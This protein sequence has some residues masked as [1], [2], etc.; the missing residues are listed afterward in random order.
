MSALDA[1][2]EPGTCKGAGWPYA[3]AGK[4]LRV[5]RQSAPTV[6]S[7]LTLSTEPVQLLS[8]LVVCV[9]APVSPAPR[10]EL[11][12]LAGWS[13]DRR[14]PRPGPAGCPVPASTAGSE[15]ARV[16]RRRTLL[17][18]GCQPPHAMSSSDVEDVGLPF[19]CPVCDREIDSPTPDEPSEAPV[20]PTPA[21]S[22]TAKGKRP[23]SVP[24]KE[25]IGPR[26]KS[27]TKLHHGSQGATKG[28]RVKSHVKSSLTAST[29][30]VAAP[31]P[32]PVVS[33]PL[34]SPTLNPPSSLYCS[35]DCRRIDEMRSR[36]AFAQLGPRPT[37]PAVQVRHDE[38]AWRAHEGT[39]QVSLMM[40]RRR[41]SGVSQRS[42]NSTQSTDYITHPAYPIADAVP[43]IDFS[44]R[45]SSRG[46]EGGYSYRP[47]LN[48]RL[49]SSDETGG[50]SWT[51]GRNRASTDSLASM[52]DVDERSSS[53]GK[54]TVPVRRQLTAPVRPPSALSSLRFMTPISA[55]QSVPRSSPQRPPPLTRSN[56]D[57]HLSS[58]VLARG[59]LVSPPMPSPRVLEG[60][61]G[62]SESDPGRDRRASQDG[63]DMPPP[64]AP[65]SQ[66]TR[67]AL[68]SSYISANTTPRNPTRSLSSASLALM[69]TSLTSK[70]YVPASYDRSGWGGP[71]RSESTASL[72]GL[73]AVG[74]MTSTSSHPM[75]VP[76][77]TF[78]SRGS[79]SSISHLPASSPSSASNS[80]FAHS[81]SSARST[82]GSSDYYPHDR[83][84]PSPPR[85]ASK[86]RRGVKGGLLMTPGSS[87]PLSQPSRESL[88]SLDRATSDR[89]HAHEPSWGDER[90]P[91]QSYNSGRDGER[92]RTVRRRA[93]DAGKPVTAS[94]PKRTHFLDPARSSSPSRRLLLANPTRRS[95]SPGLSRRNPSLS[96]LY[97]AALEEQVKVV[98]GRKNWSW[99]QLHVPTYAALDVD[100]VR[101]AKAS[102][103][104]VAEQGEGVAREA[105]REKKRLF[106]FNTDAE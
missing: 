54:S 46:S 102:A 43:S 19:W 90:T 59:R 50:L 36:L 22:A 40:S 44:T 32:S 86:T 24:K 18:N 69:G 29:P 84:A 92:D 61:P 97:D 72:S 67:E 34:A 78:R 12:E 17:T 56:T 101:E 38:G 6:G 96:H 94:M 66:L 63:L 51:H 81:H 27:T 70:S 33:S 5:A 49:A 9:V 2:P 105:P 76:S 79:S 28:A 58:E 53:Y 1:P 57:F 55:A 74:R 10:G 100:R 13:S 82:S 91:T 20:V 42:S 52:G 98:P 62:R 30:I 104:A 65:S 23:A 26:R 71:K 106:F 89:V 15:R 77:T 47:N 3:R 75:Q 48:G 83:N 64:P 16:Q 31:A 88:D 60:A 25:G 41:S 14:S 93:E 73:V 68:S 87:L 35:E 11:H 4:R 8:C 21:L 103:G 99:D 95:T 7:A 37:A 45:R 85:S 39:E 80:S